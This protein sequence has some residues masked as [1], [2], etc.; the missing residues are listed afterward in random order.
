MK[1]IG[2]LLISEYRIYSSMTSQWDRVIV[3][4]FSYDWKNKLKRQLETKF[5]KSD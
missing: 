4:E 2:C 3:Q 1:A 5:E